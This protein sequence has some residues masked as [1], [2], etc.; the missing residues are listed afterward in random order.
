MIVEIQ[1]G[2]ADSEKKWLKKTIS[3]YKVYR[4]SYFTNIF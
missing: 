4:K 1:G 2:G 3:G